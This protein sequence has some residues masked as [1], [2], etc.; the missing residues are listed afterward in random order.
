MKKELLRVGKRLYTLLNASVWLTVVSLLGGTVLPAATLAMT[1]P[2]DFIG[3]W[4]MYIADA[5]GCAGYLFLGVLT[6]LCLVIRDS[7]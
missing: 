7:E 6:L 5:I 1:L 4:Q 2:G 3:L